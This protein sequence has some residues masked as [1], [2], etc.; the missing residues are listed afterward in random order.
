MR[1][2]RL[3]SL[4]RG[5][6]GQGTTEW[7]III[8]LIVVAIVILMLAFRNPIR[9]IRG[10]MTSTVSAFDIDGGGQPEDATGGGGGESSSDAT[11][12]DAEGSDGESAKDSSRKSVGTRGLP[13][14]A[15]VFMVCVVLAIV[16]A[17][18]MTMF[19]K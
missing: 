9:D 1:P 2:T 11:T 10:E 3:S 18:I 7:V 12:T 6:S 4:R 17:L 16:V 15:W 14:W 5:S 8:A 13:V 19:G